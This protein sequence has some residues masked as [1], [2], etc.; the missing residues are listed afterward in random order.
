M[1]KT[2]ELQNQLARALADY[3]N[4]RKRTEAE[5]EVWLKFAASGLLTRLLPVLNNLESALVHL[6]DQGLFLAISDFKK[7][8]TDEGLV[9]IK[10]QTGDVYNHEL[11]EVV[12]LVPGGKKNQIAEVVL[13]GW[14]YA[15]GAVLRHAKVKVFGK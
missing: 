9:E 2:N 12:E 10:P 15:D 7:V 11:A 3:D 5:K 4:L 6:K 13:S 1:K 8:L 14:K